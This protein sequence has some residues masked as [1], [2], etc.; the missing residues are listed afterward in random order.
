M[1]AFVLCA[2]VCFLAHLASA[3]PT[4]QHSFVFKGVDKTKQQA[5]LIPMTP[6]NIGVQ[7][8]S[9]NRII[10]DHEVLHCTPKDEAVPATVDGVATVR[11]ELRLICGERVF[12]VKGIEFDPH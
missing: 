1:K 7:L 8:E 3:R 10:D 11:N 4:E 12:I 5:I 9:G 2:S 6:V